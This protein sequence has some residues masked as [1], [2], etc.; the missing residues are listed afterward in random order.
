MA[1]AIGQSTATPAGDA[2]ASPAGTAIS[3]FHQWYMVVALMLLSLIAS[4]DRTSLSLMAP[5]VKAD[6]GLDDTQLS[7]LIGGSFFLFHTLTAAPMGWLVDRYSRKVIV[8]VGATLWSLATFASGFANSYWQLFF[9][10]AGVGFSEGGLQPAGFSL[11]RD[12]ISPERRGRAFSIQMT[13]A[14][15][16]GGLAFVVGGIVI[17]LI[18]EQSRQLPL[19]G[20]VRGWQLT[21]MLLGLCGLPFAL[22]VLPMKEPA[23]PVGHAPQPFLKGYG[24]AAAFMVR[25]WRLYAPVILYMCTVGMVGGAYNVW[26]ASLVSRNFGAPLQEIGAQIG[27]AMMICFPLGMLSGGVLTDALRKRGRRLAA[28]Y[29]G[30][31]AV[32]VAAVPQT[33]LALAPTPMFFW[34]TAYIALVALSMS[35]PVGLNLLATVTEKHV[36]GRVQAIFILIQAVIGQA[37]GPIIIGRLSDSVFAWA[38]QKSLAYALASFSAICMS[39]AVLCMIWLLRELKHATLPED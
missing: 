36:T 26:L 2:Q 22:L 8:G 1:D 28:G 29:I 16:G 34:I 12:G 18:G 32:S 39:L 35:L 7:L 23:R 33:F 15:L 5:M 3:A 11:I 14:M 20:E 19:I 6:L 13:G 21:L 38:G 30:L 9:G 4:I 37:V 24:E 17:G 10:R 31:A 25:R 27:I